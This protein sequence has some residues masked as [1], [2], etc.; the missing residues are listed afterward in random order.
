MGWLL[1]TNHWIALLERRCPLLAATPPDR[2]WFCSLVKEELLH[3]ALKYG[4]PVAWSAA[5]H[6][7]RSSHT[8]LTLRHVV[9]NYGVS[10][11][12][13]HTRTKPNPSKSFS[14]AVANSLTPKARSAR[15][16]R[17]SQIRWRA[18]PGTATAATVHFTVTVQ[19]PPK[20]FGERPPAFL[21]KSANFPR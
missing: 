13:F 21:G 11:S 3:G 1:D 19:P 10:E 7:P 6:A 5:L 14:L 20:S 4:Y 8:W 17:L 2:V 15:A 9:K 12:G 16:V 18:I